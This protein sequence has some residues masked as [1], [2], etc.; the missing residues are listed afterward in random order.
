MREPTDIELSGP[1][2]VLSKAP[3][4][5]ARR[6]RKKKKRPGQGGLSP[7]A[8]GME[9]GLMTGMEEEAM[10]GMKHGGVVRSSADRISRHHNRYKI[11]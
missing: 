7:L 9:Q 4:P 8:P 10:T 1:G 6:L 11:Y 5:L 2:K 3:G